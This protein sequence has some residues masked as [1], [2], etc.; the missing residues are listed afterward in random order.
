MEVELGFI[1]VPEYR[2]D[3]HD[4][5]AFIQFAARQALGHCLGFQVLLQTFRSSFRPK[6]SKRPP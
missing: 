4:L 6:D 2:A 5:M 3:A 1:S